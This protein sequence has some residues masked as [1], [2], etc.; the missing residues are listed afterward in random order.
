[1]VYKVMQ[2]LTSMG[3]AT[4]AGRN[5][6]AAVAR[7]PID[8]NLRVCAAQLAPVAPWTDGLLGFV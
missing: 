7:P 2:H 3:A 6:G 4:G 5:A 1:M 8:K